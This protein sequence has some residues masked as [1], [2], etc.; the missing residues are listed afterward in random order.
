MGDRGRSGDGASR[1]R[2]YIYLKQ[3]MFLKDVMEMRPTT[4]NLEDTTEDTDLP[5]SQPQPPAG[6]EL[7]LSP[8][9]T[10]L[11]PAPLRVKTDDCDYCDFS[12]FGQHFVGATT[13]PETMWTGHSA[14]IRSTYMNIT[15]EE[16]L[17]R[18]AYCIKLLPSPLY[19]MELLMPTNPEAKKQFLI[20]EEEQ[21]RPSMEKTERQERSMMMRELCKDL[22][23]EKESTEENNKIRRKKIQ[24]VKTIKIKNTTRRSRIRQ[25]TNRQYVNHH[26]RGKR[27]IIWTIL[28]KPLCR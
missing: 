20:Q 23:E 26:M 24:R 2:P 12:G 5:E 17:R 10:P 19:K 3:L 27:N 14:S 28:L 18:L 21:P 13:A 1:K 25:N 8:E 6:Q 22:E 11:D 16:N 9:P 15:L 4:D 7:P